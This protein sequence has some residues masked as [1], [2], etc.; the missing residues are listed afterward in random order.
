MPSKDKK[1]IFDIDLNPTAEKTKKYGNPILNAIVTFLIVFSFAS[2][3]VFQMQKTPNEA[4]K[5]SGTFLSSKR[6]GLL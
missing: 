1:L 5:P 4:L 3:L 2:F 6:F